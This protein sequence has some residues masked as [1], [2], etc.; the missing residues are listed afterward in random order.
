[1]VLKDA[2]EQAAD[3]VT[4]LGIH[5]FTM[6][7]KSTLVASDMQLAAEIQR[8]LAARGVTIQV[9]DCGRDVGVDFAAGSRRRVRTQHTRTAAAKRGVKTVLRLRRTVK[10]ARKLVFERLVGVLEPPLPCSAMLP[11]IL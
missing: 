1:M 10:N 6:S 2:V 11:E 8:Q 5:G 3:F 9:S 4:Q 7:S